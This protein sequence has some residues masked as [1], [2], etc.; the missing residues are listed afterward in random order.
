MLH[1]QERYFHEKRLL[2]DLLCRSACFATNCNGSALLVLK[3]ANSSSS[4]SPSSIWRAEGWRYERG[5]GVEQCPLAR[6]KESSEKRNCKEPAET[7]PP[8]SL[9]LPGLANLK[10]PTSVLNNYR[11]TCSLELQC[12]GYAFSSHLYRLHHE[13]GL[14]AGAKHL[15]ERDTANPPLPPPL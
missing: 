13:I 15:F 12:A 9:S 3:S 6:Q 7:S 1:S 8:R 4:L 2:Q 10:P 5:R 14:F 11:P